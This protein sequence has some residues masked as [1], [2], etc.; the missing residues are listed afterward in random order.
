MTKELFGNLPIGSIYT[1]YEDTNPRW[2]WIKCANTP[3]N[4]ALNFGDYDQQLKSPLSWTGKDS[5]VYVVALPPVNLNREE[6]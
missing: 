5:P 3:M 6:F 1:H 4:N 2:W